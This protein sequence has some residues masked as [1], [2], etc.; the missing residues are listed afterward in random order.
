MSNGNR[1]AA[2]LLKIIIGSAEVQQKF[3]E[4]KRKK[5]AF[6]KKFVKDLREKVRDQIDANLPFMYLV[7]A[8][9]IVS[10]ML[11]ILNPIN[12][13]TQEVALDENIDNPIVQYTSP[14]AEFELKKTKTEDVYRGIEL[15]K[16]FKSVTYTDQ[17]TNK[18]TIYTNQATLDK[19]LPT[20][21]TSAYNK[22]AA[23]QQSI[24]SD[25]VTDL[26]AQIN[27]KMTVVDIKTIIDKSLINTADYKLVGNTLRTEFNA[28][29]VSLVIDPQTLLSNYNPRTQVLVIGQSFDSVT[30]RVNDIVTDVLEKALEN[31]GLVPVTKVERGRKGF[32]AGNFAAAGHSGISSNTKLIGINTPLLQMVTLLLSLKG[33]SAPSIYD[34]FVLQT[35]HRNNLIDINQNYRQLGDELLSIGLAVGRSQDTVFN[36]KNLGAQETTFINKELDKFLNNSYRELKKELES[37]LEQVAKK[38]EVLQVLTD[39][40]RMSP[41][42]KEH[43]VLVVKDT[44]DGFGKYKGPKGKA[45]AQSPARETTKSTVQSSKSTVQKAIGKKHNASKAPL[46][47]IPTKITRSFINL[48]MLMMQINASLHDQIKEN[49]GTGDRRDI[50]NYRTGRFAQSAKVEKLSESRQGMITAFYS[51]MKNPYATFSRGGQQDRPYTR[52]PKLLISKSIR[53]LAGTQVANRMRAVLV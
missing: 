45:K 32:K 8:N 47:K 25:I 4:D 27:S 46:V 24:V 53:E 7:D 51:Y 20:A 30:G 6:L 26:S 3:K 2:N 35:S 21:Y 1:N 43:I 18:T 33:K 40:F 48:P 11:N 38:P 17:K 41:T 39:T 14:F 12:S 19:N 52:D 31:T 5:E 22:L 36:S 37:A 44:F 9:V 16:Y 23:K 34:N 42:I 50:L 49:M 29:G 10:S 13:I 15:F 28:K